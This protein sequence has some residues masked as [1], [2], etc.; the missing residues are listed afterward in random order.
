MGTL[1]VVLIPEEE[2]H[3]FQE[4]DYTVSVQGWSRKRNLHQRGPHLFLEIAMKDCM[5]NTC[6]RR[7]ESVLFSMRDRGVVYEAGSWSGS[8]SIR[9]ENPRGFDKSEICNFLSEHIGLSISGLEEI[10]TNPSE[11]K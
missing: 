10:Q 11:V 4:K 2:M 5:C 9:F 8:C 6:V 3:R 7:F 1:T